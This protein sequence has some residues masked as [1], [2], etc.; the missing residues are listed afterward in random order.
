MLPKDNAQSGEAETG[1]RLMVQSPNLPGTL[2][3]A[4][5][6]RNVRSYEGDS[7]QAEASK[8]QAT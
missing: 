5:S 1:N 8:R 2:L 6:R 4:D 3:H 7:N